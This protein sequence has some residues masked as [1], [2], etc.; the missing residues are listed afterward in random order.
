MVFGLKLGGSQKTPTE[1]PPTNVSA[2]SRTASGTGKNQL[3]VN[4]FVANTKRNKQ[5]GLDPT[6]PE[7]VAYAWYLGIDPVIDSDLMWITHEAL[8]APLPS[9]W[10][11]HHDSSDRI[12]Y[13][14][15]QT[16]ISSWT[17]P[18]EKL[19]RD[20][21]KSIVNF[22]S[23]NLSKEE[24]LAE[25]ERL[26]SKCEESEREAH[27]ELQKWIEHV[28]E[29]G[30]KFYHNREKGCSVWTDPRPAPC[31]SLYLQM[32]TLRVLSKHCGQ[33]MSSPLPTELSR[34][35]LDY[36]STRLKIQQSSS[37]T[38][39]VLSADD[40]SPSN[41]KRRRKKHRDHERN[42]NDHAHPEQTVDETSLSPRKRSNGSKQT[43]SLAAVEEECSGF[44][45]P[46][47]H[48]R[49]PSRGRVQSSHGDG[50]STVGRTKVK[51]GIRLEPLKGGA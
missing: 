7:L 46:P 41:E 29:Q 10:T 12:F 49:L 23:G 14:N 19:H 25:L 30:Q 18:L 51:P 48:G 17:H 21:Y 36:D 38:E 44:G 20:T 45:G 37:S 26:R 39:D 24:Q 16:K 13:Y 2:S 4:A 50:L 28:D 32:K 5:K 33:S 3:T 35:L 6:K 40:S 1:L 42:A 22:R 27:R 47:M 11:E 31:H 8:N 15:V 9:E 43:A 34:P